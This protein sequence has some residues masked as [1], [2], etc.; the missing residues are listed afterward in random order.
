[1]DPAV[2]PLGSVGLLGVDLPGG[3]RLDQL[4]IAM[5]TGSAIRGPGRI[6]LFLGASPEAADVAGVL[7]GSGEVSWLVPR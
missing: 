3:R 6:D 7:R 5:D 2:T 1:V 4:V